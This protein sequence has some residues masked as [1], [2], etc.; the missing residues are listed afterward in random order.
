LF[1]KRWL[2]FVFVFAV[3]GA[4]AANELGWMAA[5]VGRQPWI[6]H[7]GIVHDRT[8][9]VALDSEGFV[10][11]RYEEGLLTRNGVSE[12]ITGS[13]VLGSVAM[14][15]FIYA[16]LFWIWIHV[17]NDKIQKGPQPIQKGAREA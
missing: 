5:E 6:V 13:Q 9:K 8:G 2:L 11:Y 10:Q 12:A 4:F 17:L 16:L 15:G 1:Q 7:P 14:F 3:L